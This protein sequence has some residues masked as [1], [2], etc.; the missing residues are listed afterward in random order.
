MNKTDR[1]ARKMVFLR[2]VQL[3]DLFF[4]H[5]ILIGGI[6][7][8]PWM[9]WEILV[10]SVFI[11]LGLI[12]AGMILSGMTETVEYDYL[13]ELFEIAASDYLDEFGDQ[14]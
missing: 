10:G 3:T 9:G 7:L 2:F 14:T 11:W 5:S 8:S 6:L 4:A 12:S 13:N 1:L